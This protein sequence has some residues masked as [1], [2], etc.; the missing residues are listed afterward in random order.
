MQSTL[1]TRFLGL[2]RLNMPCRRPTNSI[3]S[4]SHEREKKNKK[5]NV[6]IQLT[7][8]HMAALEVLVT[9]FKSRCVRIVV[10][11]RH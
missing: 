6:H 9:D 1:S 11:R 3:P 8:V 10:S 7:R 5:K 2:I 4:A